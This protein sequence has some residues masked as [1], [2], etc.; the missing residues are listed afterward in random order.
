MA[1]EITS[2]RP[3]GEETL[4]A[5]QVI[6]KSE[7]D[8]IS[9]RGLGSDRVSRLVKI[10][11]IVVAASGIKAKATL[12]SIQCRSCRTVIP[13]ITIKPGLEGYALPRR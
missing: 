8:S 4:Q 12:I 11:G 10:P 2:P 13:N 6:L 1:D 3:M 7:A 5:I 9:V